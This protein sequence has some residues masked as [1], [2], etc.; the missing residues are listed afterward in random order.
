M[1]QLAVVVRS[2]ENLLVPGE[3]KDISTWSVV[4]RVPAAVHMEVV[5]MDQK[6]SEEYKVGPGVGLPPPEVCQ[7]EQEDEKWVSPIFRCYFSW[8]KGR[9][10]LSLL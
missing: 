2:D 5:P 6:L 8:L 3:V 9:S 1:E 10:R 4:D 7:H